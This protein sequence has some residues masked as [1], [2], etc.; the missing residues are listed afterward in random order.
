MNAFKE[1]LVGIKGP[2]DDARQWRH[3]FTERGP[4][5]DARSLRLSAPGAMV[6]RRPL[7]CETSGE[8]GHGHLPRKYR[9]HLR[10]HRISRW[11]AGRRRK[12]WIFSPRNFRSSSAR[13]VSG[14]KEASQQWQSALE[15]VGGAEARCRRAGGRGREAGEVI[16]ARNAWSIPPSVMRSR[17]SARA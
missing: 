14:T 8:S 12:S 17:T 5:P 13:S 15:A 10:G 4:A 16:S 1:Y 6:H 3:P 11:F 7:P 9:G 2:L